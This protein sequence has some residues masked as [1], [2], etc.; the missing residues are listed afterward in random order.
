MVAPDRI[1]SRFVSFQ[2]GNS[3][4]LG[5]FILYSNRLPTNAQLLAKG[6]LAAV[7]K[8]PFLRRFVDETGQLTDAAQISINKLQE[9][10]MLVTNGES[11]TVPA[12]MLEHLTSQ[13]RTYFKVDGI[14]ALRGAAILAG[15]VW[16]SLSNPNGSA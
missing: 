12:S 15:S 2:P 13:T 3:D 4:I 10:N 11:L 9:D 14:T 6:L 7:E 5:A 8:A 1:D 16:I